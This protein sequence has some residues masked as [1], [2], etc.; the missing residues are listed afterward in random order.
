MKW[1]LLLYER[2]RKKKKDKKD[3]DEASLDMF[4][5]LG[6]FRY[7]WSSCVDVCGY[8]IS[9]NVGANDLFIYLFIYLLLLLLKKK[10]QMN[11]DMFG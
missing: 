3:K 4:S 2:E 5:F 1:L 11:L 7:V 6:W 10:E 9:I 8:W